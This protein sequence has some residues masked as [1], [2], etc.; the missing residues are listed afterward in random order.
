MNEV[1]LICACFCWCLM[2]FFPQNDPQSRYDSFTLLRSKVGGASQRS[3]RW[4]LRPNLFPGPHSFHYHKATIEK[5]P[6]TSTK[7]AALPAALPSQLSFVS[8]WCFFQ[9]WTGWRYLPASS[10]SLKPKATPLIA[11]CS[12]GGVL[13]LDSHDE[14]ELSPKIVFPTNLALQ[15]RVTSRTQ[16]HNGFS[17]KPHNTGLHN[18]VKNCWKID[19]K[20]EVMILRFS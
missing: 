8:P 9:G 1:Y 11:G 14:I 15:S 16:A 4:L 20:K 10:V 6:T 7:I 3:C 2:L 13:A 12:F 17:A 5:V 18:S 19:P